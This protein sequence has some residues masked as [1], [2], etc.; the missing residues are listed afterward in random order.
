MLLLVKVLVTTVGDDQFV[1]AAREHCAL[2]GR[3]TVGEGQGTA[4]SCATGASCSASAVVSHGHRAGWNRGV[5]YASRCDREAN[6]LSV[7]A[8]IRRSD[9]RNRHGRGRRRR[10]HLFYRG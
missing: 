5:R 10:D 1:W 9:R 4:E 3:N 8:R 2:E 7:G 6:I